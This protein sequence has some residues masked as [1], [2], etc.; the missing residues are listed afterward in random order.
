MALFRKTASEPLAVTM[1]GVKLGQR[2]LVVGIR[3][4]KLAAQLAI[5]AGLTGRACVVDD[6]EARLAKAA[7]EIEQEG[8]L[9]EPLR[10]PYGMWPYDPESFDVVVIPQLLPVLDPESR[11][12]CAS[13]VFRVLRRGGRVLVIDPAARGG[14]AALL[15]RPASDPAYKG[16]AATLQDAGFLAVREL[17]EADG[18]IYVEGIKKA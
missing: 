2:L 14:F 3:D 5:K 7:A 6:D 1:A 10:A 8:A 18:V 13:E 12:R 15:N 17:A 16:P 11:K 9:V 4:P